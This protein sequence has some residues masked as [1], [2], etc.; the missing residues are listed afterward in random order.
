M[1]YIKGIAELWEGKSECEVWRWAPSSPCL[2]LQTM[3]HRSGR[4]VG[5]V[6]A[7][8]LR[9]RK[10]SSRLVGEAD[11]GGGQ[12]TADGCERVTLVQSATSSLPPSANLRCTSTMCTLAWHPGEAIIPVQTAIKPS[13]RRS[14]S[15][16]TGCSSMELPDDTGVHSA[17]TR[18]LQRSTSSDI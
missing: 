12:E 18:P 15:A 5:A 8:G 13:R 6:E 4:Q 16:F 9:P 7:A 2:S 17:L 3:E 10:H 11:A 1:L 14:A